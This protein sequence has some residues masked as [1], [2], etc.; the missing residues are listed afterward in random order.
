MDCR[1]NQKI[2]SSRAAALQLSAMLTNDND[3]EDVGVLFCESY[4]NI[5]VYSFI[6][7]P[8]ENSSQVLSTK[9]TPVCVYALNCFRRRFNVNPLNIKQSLSYTHV[10][11]EHTKIRTNTHLRTLQ[12]DTSSSKFYLED[13]GIKTARCRRQ[14]LYLLG[15]YT[16]RTIFILMNII[17][18]HIHMET[19]L[20]LKNYLTLLYYLLF[21]YFFVNK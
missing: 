10:R 16:T 7:K 21:I 3:D 17:C 14:T 6:Y 12:I 18:I 15:R 19:R 1:T 20:P 4:I 2:M 5:R 8:T 13:D 11:N 9:S